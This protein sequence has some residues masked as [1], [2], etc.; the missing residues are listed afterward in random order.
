M[1]DFNLLGLIDEL[2]ST[3]G[4]NARAKG[5]HVDIHYDPALPTCLH[6][7][8]LRI[9]QVLTNLLD[10][11]IKFTA[12][13]S[14]TLVAE[15]QDD[16]LHFAG[17]RHRHRHRARRLEA[18]FEPFTQ[19]DASMTRRYGGTGLGTTISKQ[20]VEL[21]GGRIWV[22]SV[23]GEGSSFHV[24]LPLAPARFAPAKA[25]RAQ[26]GRCCRRCACWW[27]TTCRKTSNCWSCC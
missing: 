3:L 22:E 25:A 18:I 10:N 23:P 15:M 2:S 17:A 26:R 5:L 21:M 27:P 7:D 13:G 16:Q 20:L 1:N 4:A 8:E 24:L 19:A 14:V 12:A 9:R 11:A 6:G